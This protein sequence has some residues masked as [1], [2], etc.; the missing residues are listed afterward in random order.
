[1]FVICYTRNARQPLRLD[2]LNAATWGNAIKLN[3]SFTATSVYHMAQQSPVPTL[4]ET[5]F[6]ELPTDGSHILAYSAVINFS[7]NISMTSHVK[8]IDPWRLNDV[9][10]RP[11]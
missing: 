1:V 10:D 2:F 7:G 4:M 6:Q 5:Q 8:L 3:T 11:Q 9:A